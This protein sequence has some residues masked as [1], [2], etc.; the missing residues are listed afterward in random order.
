MLARSLFACFLLLTLVLVAA[1][2]FQAHCGAD[3]DCPCNDHTV[4]I[5]GCTVPAATCDD[6]CSSHSGFAGFPTVPGDA[7]DGG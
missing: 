5:A 4:Q 7:G 1:S 2:C 3:E 6:A